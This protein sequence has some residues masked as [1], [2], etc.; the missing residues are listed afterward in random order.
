MNTAE[1]L[2]Q[3]IK[4]VSEGLYTRAITSLTSIIETSPDEKE[5][6]L[7]RAMAYR[8]EGLY[9]ESLRDYSHFIQSDSSRAEAFYGRGFVEIKLDMLAEAIEDFTEVVRLEPNDIGAYINRGNALRRS[10]KLKEAAIDYLAALKV[11]REDPHAW[12]GLARVYDEANESRDAVHAF[13]AYLRIDK[14]NKEVWLRKGINHSKLGE[15][16]SAAAAFER[17]LKIDPA[18]EEAIKQCE[19]MRVKLSVDLSATTESVLQSGRQ[20]DAGNTARI[21]PRD[22]ALPT[23][24]PMSLKALEQHIMAGNPISIFVKDRSGYKTYVIEHRVLGQRR[25]IINFVSDYWSSTRR[26]SGEGSVSKTLEAAILSSLEHGQPILGTLSLAESHDKL[27]TRTRATFSQLLDIP[28]EDGL[29]GTEEEVRTLRMNLMRD[30]S[31]DH[32]RNSIRS[33]HYFLE[34]VD[35][36]NVDL[37][38]VNAT[39]VR[40]SRSNLTNAKLCQATLSRANFSK[41]IMQ[42]VDLSRASAEDADFSEADM[43][44]VT[45]VKGSFKN[46]NFRKANLTGARFEKADLQG[47]DFKDAILDMVTFANCPVN[48]QTSLPLRNGGIPGLVWK[49]VGRNP[50]APGSVPMKEEDCQN[51]EDLLT[52]LQTH[53]DSA[54]I[55]KALTMLKAQRFELFA[56]VSATHLAGIVKSQTDAKLIYG[57]SLNNEGEFFCCTQNLNKCGGLESDI[58]KHLLVLIIG[59]AKAGRVA[60]S[61]VA[62]WSKNSLYQQPASGEKDAV[63]ALFIKYKSAELGELDWRPSETVPED[64]YAI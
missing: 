60:W 12:L 40:F 8:K 64:Y 53:L 57:C 25:A 61:D 3:G 37:Q 5:A 29:P 10:G 11:D 34:G 48:E 44:A 43:S 2:E 62:V 46:A 45:A 23:D 33:S 41:S 7:V 51:L 32:L 30:A 20:T 17:V 6:Y 15:F 24:G 18:D 52:C 27:L 59:L 38:G 21:L 36:Q 49:G 35:L 55:K 13:D 28:L 56:D 9:K 63:G 42:N 47:A 22:N 50:Y 31:L 54:R 1:L 16:S 58:C 26:R 4:L 19:L 14:S 39:G